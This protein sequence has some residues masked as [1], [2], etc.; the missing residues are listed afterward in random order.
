MKVIKFFTTTLIVLAISGFT[1]L[2]AQTNSD[3]CELIFYRPSQSMMSGGAGAELKVYIN[4]QEVGMLPNGTI[5]KYKIYSQGNLKIKFVGIMANTTVGKPMVVNVEAKH[6]ETI[7][8]NTSVTFPD[9]ANAK[10]LA[11]SKEKE[12]LKKE[13][14]ADVMEEKE[15]IEKPLIPVEN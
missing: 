15:N 11:T 12:K 10:I 4:N 6:G 9:G 3:A 13:K 8:F 2:S 1:K 5:L 14:W 7:E